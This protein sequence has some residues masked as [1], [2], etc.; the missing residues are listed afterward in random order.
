MAQFDF[1][2]IA[3]QYELIGGF[4]ANDPHAGEGPPV[5]FMHGLGADRNQARAALADLPEIR[6][7]ILD[8]PG[9][10]ETSLNPAQ[11]LQEQVG[12]AAYA[13]LAR[14]LLAHLGIKSVIAGGISMGAGIALKLALNEPRLV[15]RLFLVRPAWLAKPARPNLEMIAQIETLA[16]R[17]QA[18]RI[19]LEESAIERLVERLESL[20]AFQDIHSVSPMA[21]SSVCETARRAWTGKTAML[22]RHL[23]DD[24]PFARMSDLAQITC[25]AL[26][27]GNSH[28]PLHPQDMALTLAAGLL[29]GRYAHLPSRYQEPESHQMAVDVHARTFM[30]PPD[31]TALLRRA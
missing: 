4:A 3:V 17:G 10:G 13:R 7:I 30:L 11:S 27:L 1:G 14:A 26:V 6:A 9:H 22:F 16:G 29:Q 24:Q 25:P 5:L 19:E 21:A 31:P 18:R 2:G 20:P 8:M 12:F 23:V 15:D 28:D